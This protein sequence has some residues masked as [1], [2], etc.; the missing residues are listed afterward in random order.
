[1]NAHSEKPLGV[2]ITYFDSSRNVLRLLV[3]DDSMEYDLC[4]TS[5]LIQ[6]V[7]HQFIIHSGN[8][9]LIFKD[10]KAEVVQNG[11]WQGAIVYIENSAVMIPPALYSV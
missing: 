11:L 2:V 6:N 8:H 3:A 7:G 1:M 5:R 4:A 9:K 10:G